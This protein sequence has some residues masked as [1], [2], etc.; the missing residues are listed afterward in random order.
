[1]IS[2][3][4]SKLWRWKFD[5][6]GKERLLALGSYPETS[7]S[8]AR[9]LRDEARALV[10][11]GIDPVRE[12]QQEKALAVVAAGNTFEVAA[13]L[14]IDRAR[15]KGRSL[16]T[17]TR[18]ERHKRQAASL[19]D[20]PIAS[21]KPHEVLA[22]VKDLAARA[23][24]SALQLQSWF[25]AVFRLAISNQ[26]CPADPTASLRGAIA[27]PTPQHQPALLDHGPLGALLRAIDTYRGILPATPFALRLAPHVVLRPGELRQG[28]WSEVDLERAVWTIPP[29][30]MKK[31]REHVVP[32]SRQALAILTELQS[33]TGA[34]AHLFPGRGVGCISDATMNAALA[35]LG[36]ANIHSMHGFRSS[37]SSMANVSGLWS[38]DAVERQ[39]AHSSRNAVRSAYMRDPFWQERVKLMQWWSDRIDLMRATLPTP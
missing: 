23:P 12:R 8:D 5:L 2:P 16:K 9:R 25:G 27:A 14:Y 31:R 18:M 3:N 6:A 32:L 33:I 22:V 34:C 24:T 39:L 26:M 19:A 1:L 13:E 29:E 20:R 30:R 4:G 21:I 38:E 11:R 17:V 10:K 7:L 15:A 37:F 28:R 36:F 35:V